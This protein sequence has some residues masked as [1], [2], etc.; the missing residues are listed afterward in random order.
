MSR[1]LQTRQK[2]G[3]H[4]LEIETQYQLEVER[5]AIPRIR[6]PLYGNAVP[7]SR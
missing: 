2:E 7:F 6:A 5:N 3:Q 4:V 1:Y